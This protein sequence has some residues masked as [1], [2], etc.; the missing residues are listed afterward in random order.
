MKFVLSPPRPWNRLPTELKLM[1]C[2]PVFK[3]SLKTFL[4]QTAYCS[5]LRDRT[6][7]VDSVMRPHSSSTRRTKS[8]DDYNYDYECCRSDLPR[9]PV[10]V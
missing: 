1:R 5:W 3:R 4:F 9:R 2:T 8:T 7:Q 6:I 10:T